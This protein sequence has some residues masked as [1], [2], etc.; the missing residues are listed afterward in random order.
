MGQWNARRVRARGAA[1]TLLE[2]RS[3][4]LLRELPERCGERPEPGLEA[5]PLL[6]TL[7]VDGPPHLLGARRVHAAGGLVELQAARLEVEPAEIQY[8]PH[9][10]LE[11]G[12]QLLV[13]HAQHLS[14][15]N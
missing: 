12:D 1:A 14:R 10:R 9:L 6:E 4:R 15:Q 2:A 7:G 3:C 11:V 5:S 13:L 8:P